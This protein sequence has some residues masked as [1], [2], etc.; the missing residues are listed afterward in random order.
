MTKKLIFPCIALTVFVIVV[1]SSVYLQAALLELIEYFDEFAHAHPVLGPVLFLLLAV[2]SVLLGPFSSIPLMP[3][4]IVAWGIPITFAY[5]LVG[6]FI[7]GYLSYLIGNYAG[8][9]FV[10]W[11]VGEEKLERWLSPLR[12]GLPFYL[13][14]LFRLA[15]PAETGYAFG[16]IGYSMR[17]Y[18][19]I[20]FLAEVPFALLGVYAGEAFLENGWVTFV[21]LVFAALVLVTIAYRLFFVYFDKHRNDNR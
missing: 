11:L 13:M 20:V 6:W 5:T 16:L 9:P 4:A 19:L 15:M 7:G 18:L 10:A 2:S 12:H 8:K 3:F 1:A 17:K 14:L 21:S